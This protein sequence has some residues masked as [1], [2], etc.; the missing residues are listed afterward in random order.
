MSSAIKRVSVVG[1]FASARSAEDDSK[2]FGG[3]T[4][5][6]R[7]LRDWLKSCDGFDYSEVDTYRW[8]KNP[9]R[10]FFRTIRES[11]R[12]D[13][14]LMALSENGLRLIMPLLLRL[15]LIYGF[16]LGYVVIG[17]WVAKRCEEDSTLLRRL[18]E[19]D[20]IFAETTSMADSLRNLGLD[21]ISYVPNAK[22]LAVLAEPAEVDV[23]VRP[24]PLC[25][26]SRVC[27]EKGVTTAIEAVARVNSERGSTEYF[28]DVYGPVAEDYQDEFNSL[29]TAHS[30][31]VAYK[32]SVPAGESVGVLSGYLLL[33]LPTRYFGEGFPGTI[34]DA[35]SA[36]VP[37]VT[38]DWQ[39]ARSIVEDGQTGLIYGFEDQE[40]AYATLNKCLD[41]L[42]KVV[43]MR[44]RCLEES[45]KYTPD[46]ANEPIWSFLN[47]P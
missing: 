36:G 14:V 20:A 13:V 38:S 33:L 27:R 15:R 26:F 17:G 21:N 46:K 32:G 5:K 37:V 41:D 24:L 40:G 11:R 34:V 45:A 29:L 44:K 7:M 9:L 2:D 22:K 23:S 28:L 3:Q 8:K 47:E 6:C 12:A 25:V 43:G 42:E 4:A 39:N 30:D 1:Y 19:L 18:S 35:F 10:L 16:R 31:C